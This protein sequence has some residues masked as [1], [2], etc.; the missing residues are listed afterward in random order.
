[1]TRFFL[2]KKLLQSLLAIIQIAS[3]ALTSV[4]QHSSFAAS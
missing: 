1:L 2:F 3:A 4:V